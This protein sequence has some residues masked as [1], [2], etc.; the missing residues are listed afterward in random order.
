MAED[1][2]ET[3]TSRSGQS[4][5]G[6]P[7]NLDGSSLDPTA[8]SFRSSGGTDASEDPTVFD[9]PKDPTDA[10]PQAASLP[11]PTSP[12]LLGEGIRSPKGALFGRV[13]SPRSHGRRV[14]SANLLGATEL[15]T[16]KESEMS[17]G[18]WE[19]RG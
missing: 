1:E 18:E 9:Q 6:P 19:A 7:L 5:S 11:P 4:K 17:A 14:G 15:P 8:S 16:R 2:A 13:R 12:Q 10:L 3:P